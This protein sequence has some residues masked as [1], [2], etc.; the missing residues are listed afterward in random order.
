[1]GVLIAL[2]ENLKEF[3]LIQVPQ[4]VPDY[5]T[6]SV[7]TMDYVQGRK[8]TSVGPLGRL[9]MNGGF[10]VTRPTIGLEIRTPAFGSSRCRTKYGRSETFAGVAAS[11]PSP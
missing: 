10:R 5:T 3:D 1:M 4:P 2:G 11:T 9:E 8:I 6:R 7:L